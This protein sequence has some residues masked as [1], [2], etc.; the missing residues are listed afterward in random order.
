MLLIMCVYHVRD[1]ANG[2]GWRALVHSAGAAPW[3]AGMLAV[4]AFPLLGYMWW[5]R[6]PCHV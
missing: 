1:I 5:Q 4:A 3:S 6:M 2:A